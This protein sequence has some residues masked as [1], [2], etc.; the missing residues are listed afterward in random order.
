MQERQI[1]VDLCNSIINELR[2][3][4]NARVET[5]Q[6]LKR[7][8]LDIK[9]YKKDFDLKEMG[10]VLFYVNSKLYSYKEDGNDKKVVFTDTDIIPVGLLTEVEEKL[11]YGIMHTQV[12]RYEPYDVIVNYYN[13]VNSPV[14]R[15][16]KLQQWYRTIN[17]IITNI[18][19]LLEKYK[20][21]DVGVTIPFIPYVGSLKSLK[22]IFLLSVDIISGLM[23]NTLERF[24]L[25]NNVLFTEIP[26]VYELLDEFKQDLNEEMSEAV[27]QEMI[28]RG[29]GKPNEKG[30]EGNAYK[31]LFI[32][33]NTLVKQVVKERVEDNKV[34]R[35]STL[36]RVGVMYYMLKDKIDIALMHKVIYFAITPEKEYIKDANDTIYTYLT[37]PEERFLSKIDTIDF[38]KETLRKY[39]F[40]EEEILKI[41]IANV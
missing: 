23:E 16:A 10:E 21:E 17:E 13:K 40:K 28:R 22:K 4:F 20:G 30:E 37:H 5:I 8:L 7:A 15:K 31:R 19:N 26:T 24:Q 32:G 33:N 12:Y 34:K 6:D 36:K 1:D 39:K 27:R 41:D 38:I 9:S 14:L 18:D 25:E 3:I 11:I 2:G 29:Y 35:E